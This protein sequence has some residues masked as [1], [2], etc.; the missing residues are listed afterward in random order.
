M[1]WTE[2]A[3]YWSKS[4]DSGGIVEAP[5]PSTGKKLPIPNIK[6]KHMAH[7][8]SMLDT[9]P[10]HTE[11]SVC[12]VFISCIF[13]YVFKRSYG[14]V[15][16]RSKWSSTTRNRGGSVAQHSVRAAKGTKK[17]AFYEGELSWSPPPSPCLLSSETDAGTRELTVHCPLVDVLPNNE[18]KARIRACGQWRLTTL[19][20]TH[21]FTYVKWG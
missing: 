18:R 21:L 1:G 11:S 15:P 19:E 20:Q 14:C 9:Q 17:K 5:K 16:K 10:Q 2:K 3:F 7:L 6:S 4:H 13:W 12:P 8:C